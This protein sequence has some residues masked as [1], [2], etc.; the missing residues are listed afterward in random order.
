MAQRNY[1]PFLPPVE[2][3]Y[4]VRG[5]RFRTSTL[6]FETSNDLYKS[7]SKAEERAINIGCSGYRRVTT[8]SLGSILYGPCS[9]PDTYTSLM[10]EI[11]PNSM[12]RRY[13]QFDPTNNIYDIRDSINDDVREGFDYKNQIFERSLSSVIFRD[14]RKIAI[15]DNMQR[16]VFGL[17]ESVKQIRNYFNY[18]VPFNNKRV[19]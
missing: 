5:L 4:T 2:L 19:F 14:P 9:N 3:S 18:T 7:I 11:K 15:L 12:E 16:V 13:Y 6:D 8:D 10:K 17:I 1:T